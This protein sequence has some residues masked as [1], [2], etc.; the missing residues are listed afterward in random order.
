MLDLRSAAAILLTAALAVFAASLGN[1]LGRPASAKTPPLQKE[2]PRS[3]IP[4]ATCPITQPPSERFVPPDPY[5]TFHPTGTFWLGSEKLWTMRDTDGLWHGL[6]II[7]ADSGFTHEIYRDKVFWWRKGYDWRTE[8]P[9]QFKVSG[10]RLDAPA[11]PLYADQAQPTF[12]K[13]PAIGTGIDIPT[14]G[15]WEITGDYKGDKLTFVV[16][17]VP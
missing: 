8:N 6:R 11:P 1:E 16:W 14:V 2:T 13:I 4:P 3:P 10:K 15:C 5:P 9:P 7:D 17:V 12:I